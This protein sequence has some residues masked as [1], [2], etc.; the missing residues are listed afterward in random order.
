MPETNEHDEKCS[1][2]A[3]PAAVQ[4]SAAQHRT[5][6]P[7]SRPEPAVPQGRKIDTA[8]ITA[9]PADS[10]AARIRDGAESL[11]AHRAYLEAQAARG[12]NTSAG[13][14]AP[15][16]DLSV[17]YRGTGGGLSPALQ[18]YD[19]GRCQVQANNGG[20]LGTGGKR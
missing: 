4:K 20:R 3:A 14:T 13:G 1:C 15:G 16:P 19:A 12:G 11:A 18:A 2:K 6:N 5:P 17:T 10:P 8:N 7:G 9:V